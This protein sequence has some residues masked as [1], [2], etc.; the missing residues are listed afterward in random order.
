VP[1]V[2]IIIVLI[3]DVIVV[4]VA[5]VL[6]QLLVV[7]LHSWCPLGFLTPGH[8][9]LDLERFLLLRYVLQ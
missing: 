3:V 9:K 5:R 7:E 8:H 4:V 6:L 1:L 2:I